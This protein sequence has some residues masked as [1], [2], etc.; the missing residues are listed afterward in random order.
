MRAHTRDVMPPGPTVPNVQDGNK[1]DSHANWIR[2]NVT[3]EPPSEMAQCPS[4]RN[5]ESKMSSEIK[6]PGE[7]DQ[8][9]KMAKSKDLRLQ[10]KQEDDSHM[11]ENG[12]GDVAE[13]GPRRSS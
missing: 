12:A 13:S 8:N 6:S 5:Q 2:G 9:K 7:Q 11:N 3:G 10:T 1:P 4:P